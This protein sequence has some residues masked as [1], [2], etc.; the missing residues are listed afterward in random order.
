MFLR[1]PLSISLLVRDGIS[2]VIIRTL[3]YQAS[4]RRTPRNDLLN[5]SFIRKDNKVDSSHIGTKCLFIELPP[6][7]I[8]DSKQKLATT[9]SK[10]QP[11]AKAFRRGFIKPPPTN[12][13]W[14]QAVAPLYECKC[15]FTEISTMQ[16]LHKALQHAR[17]CHPM[18]HELGCVCLL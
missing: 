3:L 14:C 18:L 7:G 8:R 6:D 11:L 15:D 17:A 10:D 12:C 16:T 1:S 2:K 9:G 5:Q 13:S 4:F